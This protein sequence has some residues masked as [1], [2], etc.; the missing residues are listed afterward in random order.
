MA[1]RATQIATVGDGRDRAPAS[2]GD[3][4]AAQW[5]CRRAADAQR[6]AAAATARL[7]CLESPDGSADPSAAAG[8]SQSDISAVIEKAAKRLH[9]ILFS[10]EEISANAERIIARV[11]EEIETLRRAGHLKSVNRSYQTYRME[12]AARGEKAAPYADWFNKY[13]ANLVRQLAGALRYV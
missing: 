11:D 2:V 3:P 8:H 13:R 10:D 9:V 5:W 1:P 12:A 6:V 4:V 7:R